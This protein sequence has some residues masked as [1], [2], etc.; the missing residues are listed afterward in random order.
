MP[1]PDFHTS[2]ERFPVVHSVA[3]KPLPRRWLRRATRA[4]E[5]PAAREGT[6]L[7]GQYNDT[8]ELVPSASAPDDPAYTTATMLLLVST[9]FQLVPAAV[10]LA[11]AQP[12]HGVQISARFECRVTDPVMLLQAG[13]W[14]VEPLL[15]E[16]LSGSAKLRMACLT[17]F[18]PA[19]W[20]QFQQT[21]LALLFAHNELSPPQLPG[22]SARLADVLITLTPIPGG[23]A[24]GF[25]GDF[26]TG[27]QQP[28]PAAAQYGGADR[29]DAAPPMDGDP[30]ID[31]RYRWDGD[32]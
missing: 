1:E 29:W 20:A 11:S 4:A 25:G 9:R 22:F 32:A 31:R 21:V 6:V 26:G 3:L 8:Y 30:D 12:R 16:R 19:G 28:A 10:V 17:R 18:E 7:V 2:A 24:E 13:G 27:P 23:F 15:A 14:N 5:I